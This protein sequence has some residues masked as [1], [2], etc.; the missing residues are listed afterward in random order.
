MNESAIGKR[1]SWN[2]ICALYP[3][4]WVVFADADWRNG[5]NFRAEVVAIHTK[6]RDASPDVK[7]VHAQ[8]REVGCFWTGELVPKGYCCRFCAREDHPV[9]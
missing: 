1:L 3:D 6:R 8:D 9:R 2:K 7:A 4:R 5:A